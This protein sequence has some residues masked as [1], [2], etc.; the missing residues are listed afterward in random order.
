MSLL[1]K[2]NSARLSVIGNGWNNVSFDSGDGFVFDDELWKDIALDLD[3]EFDHDLDFGELDLPE[4]DLSDI[5]FDLD[6]TIYTEID[7]VWKNPLTGAIYPGGGDMWMAEGLWVNASDTIGALSA[8]Y[9]KRYK[10]DI[11]KWQGGHAADNECGIK[12]EPRCKIVHCSQTIT[13]DPPAWII[14]EAE[15]VGNSFTF[16][17][18]SDSPFKVNGN[19]AQLLGCYLSLKDRP[20]YYY[21]SINVSLKQYSWIEWTNGQQ[22]VGAQIAN[23]AMMKFPKLDVFS[24]LVYGSYKHYFVNHGGIFQTDT[25]ITTDQIKNGTSGLESREYNGKTYYKV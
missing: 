20:V 10:Y 12:E 18:Y 7:G 4:F 24:Q 16:G 13:V 5:I 1:F 3:Y 21:G 14:D 25:T 2:P 11:S 19:A 8:E 9:R 23:Q 6:G 17:F 22:G 15:G